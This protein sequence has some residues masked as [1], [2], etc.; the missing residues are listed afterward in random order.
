MKNRIGLLIRSLQ[1]NPE[2][3]R[4]QV[5]MA[6]LCLK[7]FDL[8]QRSAENP[9]ALAEIRDTALGAEFESSQAQRDWLNRAFGHSIRLPVLANQLARRALAGC[10]VQGPAYLTLL[11]TGFLTDPAD[12]HL[13]DHLRQVL[14]LRGYDPRTQF[15]AGQIAL[16]SGDQATAMKHWAV[17]FHANREFRE[18]I[19]IILSRAVPASLILTEFTP[20]VTELPEV[21]AAYR[22]VDRP[23]QLEQI[24]FEIGRVTELQAETATAEERIAVLMDGYDAAWN[25]ALPATAED[26]L[27]R[28]VACDATAYWPKHALG[29]LLFEQQQYDEA[30]E[31]FRWCY[32]Q[33]PGDTGL[34]RL[35]RESRRLALQQNA[36]VMNTS[37]RSQ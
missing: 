7:L 17:V 36:P 27:R 21:L 6:S 2:Q 3:P 1:A 28:A 22:R 32:D 11:D 23:R 12:A 10:P 14:Q 5:R 33:Q 8:M 18:A 31:L 25:A 16:L 20:S 24:L 34:E 35:V 19:T 9:M 15:V 4:A 26:M 30:A 13:Q 37:Y 29:L